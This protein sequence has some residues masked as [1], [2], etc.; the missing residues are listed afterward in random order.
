MLFPTT[1]KGEGFPGVIIDAFIAGLPVIASNWNMNNEIIVDGV[2]GFIFEPN[3]CLALVEKM[4]FCLQNRKEI[5]KIRLANA[6]SGQIYHIDN[7]WE[8]LAHSIL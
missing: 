2:N 5:K 7:L 4:I 8:T 3:N 1:W 6:N